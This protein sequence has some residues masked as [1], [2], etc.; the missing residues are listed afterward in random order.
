[1]TP[2]SFVDDGILCPS[3][4]YDDCGDDPRYYCLMN[5]GDPLTPLITSN[6]KSA[7]TSSVKY[8]TI[9]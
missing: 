1:M 7:R 3:I 8:K 9:I 5:D 2:S 6:N 4:K